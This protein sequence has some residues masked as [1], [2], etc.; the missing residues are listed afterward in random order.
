LVNKAETHILNIC[1][2]DNTPLAAAL[3]EGN[4][5]IVQLLLQRGVDPNLRD[6]RQRTPLYHLVWFYPAHAWLNDLVWK[7][8]P[9]PAEVAQ[10]IVTMSSLL[11][12]HDAEVDVSV[13]GKTL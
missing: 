13:D 5:E 1:C 9:N 8:Q 12:K 3:R 6:S 10:M 2:N 7:K 11:I 4:I